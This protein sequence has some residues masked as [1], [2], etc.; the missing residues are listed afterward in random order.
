[1]LG[2]VHPL[3]M[4]TVPWHSEVC[5]HAEDVSHGY[6]VVLLCWVGLG[7]VL[8]G[9]VGLGWVGLCGPSHSIPGIRKDKGGKP[10]TRD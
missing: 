3:C 8:L 7:W 6:H 10:G 1:M 2:I 4:G 9:W 5:K